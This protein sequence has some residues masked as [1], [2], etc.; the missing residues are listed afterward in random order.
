MRRGEGRIA[1]PTW[2]D[3]IPRRPHDRDRQPGSRAADEPRN[4]GAYDAQSDTRGRHSHP[5]Y[6]AELNPIDNDDIN[7]K[8]SER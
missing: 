7:T 1:M 4:S 2:T 3:E 8:G 6:D 5:G